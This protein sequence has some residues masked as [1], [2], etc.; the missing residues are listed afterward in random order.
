MANSLVFFFKELFDVPFEHGVGSSEH[1][2]SSI[3]RFRRYF[4]TA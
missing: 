1:R 4:R 2:Y 3:H